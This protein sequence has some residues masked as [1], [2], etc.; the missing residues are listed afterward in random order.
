MLLLGILL[1]LSSDVSY[2]Q[3]GFLKSFLEKSFKIVLSNKNS[4]IAFYLSFVLLLVEVD[5]ILEKKSCKKDVLIT[6]NIDY[7]EIVFKPLTKLI[8]L[9]L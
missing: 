7:I 3:C 5:P 6:R 4:I 9:H 1:D 8:A 2:E